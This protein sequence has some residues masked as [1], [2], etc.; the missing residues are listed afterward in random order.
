MEVRSGGIVKEEFSDRNLLN[1][2]LL[3]NI[4]CIALLIRL[5]TW[6]I[7]A[8]NQAAA[9]VGAHPGTQCFATWR[10]REN[11]RPWCLVPVLQETGEPHHQECDAL[12]TFWDAYWQPVGPDLF[13]HYAFDITDRKRVEAALKESEKR[14]RD[15]ADNI[16]QWVWEVDPQGRNTYA[17]PV[18]EKGKA[19]IEELLRIDPQVKAIVSS[20]YS[21]DPIMANF[22]EYGFSGVITKPYRVAELSE[23]LH[24]VLD[25]G[26]E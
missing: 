24:R 15:I 10:Q 19:A 25:G 21:D 6:T 20:G 3:D 2:V 14:F 1:Q 8:S 9:K 22:A 16:Q 17:S 26:T 23:V 18:V 12:G 4:P 11:A 7:V 13:L 5:S